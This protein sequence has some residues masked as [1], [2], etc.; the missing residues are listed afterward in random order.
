MLEY[1][2][3]M[4]LAPMVR[5]GTLPMRLL[6][7]KYGANI[8]YSPEIIAQKLVKCKRYENSKLGT[9]DFMEVAQNDQ[10]KLVLRI[11]E[12]ERQ[13]LVV[14]IG[15]SDPEIALIAAKIVENDCA[16]IDLNCGCPKNFSIKGN[17]GAALLES[18]DLLI[19]ILTKLVSGLKIPVTCKIRLLYPKDG[20]TSQERTIELLQ[21]AE[22]T[23]IKAI[24]VHCRFRDER[25]REPGHQE[26]FDELAKSIKI[27]LIGN[28]DFYELSDVEKMRNSAISSFM[29]ARGAQWNPSIFR[30]E[31]PLEVFQI[32]QEYLKIAFQYEMP[33]H[34]IKYTLMQMKLGDSI[35][36]RKMQKAK[37][38]KDLLYVGLIVP[39]WI[40]NAITLTKIVTVIPIPLK[41]YSAIQ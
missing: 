11:D 21:K 9:V 18:Q 13:K 24:G 25:P 19:S 26:V 28:G 40:W 15:A 31:G 4:I 30:K 33:M 10:E 39:S 38:M 32:M 37:T 5:V 1:A 23:G 3:K 8:V 29:I 27:P 6:A 12:S 7:L 34:N 16:G 36:F 14:Q 22:R 35:L 2:N 17:M 41:S 20:K